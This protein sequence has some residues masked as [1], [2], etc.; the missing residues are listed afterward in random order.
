MDQQFLIYI[1]YVKYVNLLY[2][3]I[4]MIT[5]EIRRIIHGY[6]EEILSLQS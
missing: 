5:A 6:I 2:K 4:D 1:K 3:R